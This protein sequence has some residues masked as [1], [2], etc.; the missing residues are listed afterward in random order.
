MNAFSPECLDVL[1]ALSE[2]R[3]VLISGPPAAGKSRLLNE[4][5]KAFEAKF[6]AP[7]PTRAPVL[8]PSASVPI[9]AKPP[10]AAVDPALQAVQPSPGRSD[11]KVFRTVF[12]QNSKHREFLTGLTPSIKQV[13]GFEVTK[14][15]LYRAS[16]HARTQN[17]A[18]LLIID[19]INRGPAVQVFGGAIVAIE[20]EKRLGQE[21]SP[22]EATQYFELLDPASGAMMEY[23]FPHH[24]Y[25]LGAM[26]QADVS[27]EP[28]DV[29]FLRRWAPYPLQPSEAVLRTYF[30]LPAKPQA[31]AAEP[32]MAGDVYEALVQAWAKV[33]AD[34]AL[35]RTREF[36]VGHGVVMPPSGT[37]P[38]S[39][40]DALALAAR[41]WNIIRAHLDEVFFGDVRGLAVVLNATGQVAGHPYQL[42]DAFFGDEPKQEL[43]GPTTVVPANVYA[44]LSA[45]AG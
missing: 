15:I 39:L 31:L 37:A 41:S 32:T 23:A 26:N 10:A 18:S 17:G 36:Q 5:A 13:G 7:T 34:I 45:V 2:R 12:H 27:V 29:A 40:D 24:L 22:Q 14:G 21:G 6:A 19:E 9:P 1:S 16:E 28:L 43:K 20:G 30:G 33:N 3:N 35:G 8:D 4:V 44:I 42:G 38:P 25:I 11:R